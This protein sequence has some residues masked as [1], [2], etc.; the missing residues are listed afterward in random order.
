MSNNILERLIKVKDY[1]IKKQLFK[2][3]K[4][5]NL[6]LNEVLLLIYFLNQDNPI[7]NINYIKEEIL[8][9][10]KN[11]LESFSKLSTKK[12][13][14][15]RMEKMTDGKMQEVVDLSNVY[16]I[17]VSDIN[18]SIKKESEENIF[19]TFEKE[20]GRPLS[21]IEY[22]MIN[23]WVNSG[24]NE[25]LIVGALKEATFNGVKNLRYIDRIIHEWGK[26][27]FKNMNDVNKHLENREKTKKKESTVLFDYNWLEDE[28]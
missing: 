27:G 23:A 25:E 2:V 3:I 24:M 16:K 22:E 26:K 12:L 21:P 8:L 20:F 6:T 14:S 15:I 13:I 19:Q 28:E 11:I 1:T 7:L 17:M 10:E 18:I 4:E 5:T 9:D